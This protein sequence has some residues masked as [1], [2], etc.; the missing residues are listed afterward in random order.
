[1]ARG[2]NDSRKVT[3]GGRRKGKAQ[4]SRNRHDRA[5][6]KYRGQGR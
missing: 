3:F 1:M 6:R 2:V 4:K 5:N